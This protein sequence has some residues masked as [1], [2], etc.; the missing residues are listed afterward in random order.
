[1]ALSRNLPT[2]VW[3]YI[4]D[5]LAFS[6]ITHVASVCRHWSRAADVAQL[7]LDVY[8]PNVNGSHHT[9]LTW[10]S[11]RCK[12]VRDLR[13][14]LAVSDDVHVVRPGFKWPR[15]QHLAISYEKRPTSLK[16]KYNQHCLWNILVGNGKFMSNMRELEL[17]GVKIP[18]KYIN[19]MACAPRLNSL[20]LTDCVLP[21]TTE[22][23]VFTGLR[24]LQLTSC[25]SVIN[26]DFVKSMPF[27]KRFT[28][29]DSMFLT[30]IDAIIS[31]KN[32]EEFCI[33]LF[34]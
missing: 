10:L 34:P 9:M 27:L 21:N 33:S 32:I 6:D 15:L 12:R 29:H 28:V 20:R 8:V 17:D 11:S 30:S 25:V 19:T 24:S 5:K 1:M 14:R 4:F 13:L 23:A 31:C 22:L 16:Q 3:T 26:I 7:H 18:I 2:E